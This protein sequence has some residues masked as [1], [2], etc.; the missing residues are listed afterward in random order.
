MQSSRSFV[1]VTT[2]LHF[3]TTTLA[4]QLGVQLNSLEI[5]K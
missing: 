3:A 2:L 1:R 4:H 5:E